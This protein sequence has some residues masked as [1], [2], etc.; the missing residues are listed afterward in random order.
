MEHFRNPLIV[1]VD[2]PTATFSDG[3]IGALLSSGNLAFSDAAWVRDYLAGN[4]LG[5]VVLSVDRIADAGLYNSQL[6][7][8]SAGMKT[9]SFTLV[10]LALT[11]STAV[12]ALAYAIYKGRRMFVQRTA[13]W[14]WPKSLA[15]RFV[16]EGTL[17]GVIAVAMFAALGAAEND[18]VWWVLASVPL[19]A[20]A[21]TALHIAAARGIFT[22]LLARRA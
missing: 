21:S 12:S 7:N 15:G 5:E 20:V 11:M 1:L 18:D 8:Q 14:S 6:Q 17:A 2:D 13:G 19:Y 9:L 4:P 10:L 3:T 22:Q 16:W